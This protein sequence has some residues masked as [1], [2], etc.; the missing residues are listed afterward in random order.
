MKYL[1][2]TCVVSDFVKGE[3]GVLATVKRTA[4]DQIAVSAVTR[5]EVEY[6]LLLN[7]QRARRLAPVLDTFFASITVLPFDDIDAKAAAAVRAALR[8]Q[9]RPIGPYDCLIAGC[10]LARGLVVVTSNASE[11]GRISG[12]RMENW[13]VPV[14]GR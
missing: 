2:D 8:V 11:F 12:L 6:G 1:L 5:M 13:R 7:P 9:G 4:P 3:P 14:A 10:G